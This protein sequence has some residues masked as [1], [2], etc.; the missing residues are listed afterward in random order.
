MVAKRF[1]VLAL[2]A[3][4]ISFTPPVSADDNLQSANIL[5][6]GVSSSG[7]VCYDDECSPGDEVD[8]WK[9]YAYRG[10]IVQVSFSGSIPNPAWWCPGDG[11]EGD[12]SIH[13]SSGG[14]VASLSLS[15]DNPSA[16]LSKTMTTADWVYVKVKGKDSWCNDA[17]QYTLTASIDSGD[18]DTDEDG[19]IDTED[20]CDN[21]PGTSLYDRKG[22]IDTDSDGY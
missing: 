10:D 17:I 2:A 4:M 11:W 19:F 15:D 6:E 5:T 7:Y 22:C 16:S 12:Y 21:V 1:M 14:Q 20:D 18:R 8:W 9:V 13:D 3:L